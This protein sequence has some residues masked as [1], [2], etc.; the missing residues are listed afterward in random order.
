M[1]VIGDPA[2]L[3]HAR[4]AFERMSEPQHQSDQLRCGSPFVELQRALAELIEQLARF[5]SKVPV[6]IACDRWRFDGFSLIQRPT[7][8]SRAEPG[9]LAVVRYAGARVTGR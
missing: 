4:G 5:D 6:G 1:R 9:P 8:R 7:Q 3:D 2:L